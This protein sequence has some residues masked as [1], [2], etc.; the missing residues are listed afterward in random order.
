MDNISTEINQFLLDFA[1]YLI[2]LFSDT[3]ENVRNYSLDVKQTINQVEAQTG[4]EQ[5]GAGEDKAVLPSTI[6]AKNIDTLNFGNLVK[7]FT[8]L[9]RR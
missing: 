1:S 7:N 5:N 6:K 9:L 8:G 4:T 3:S 2:E